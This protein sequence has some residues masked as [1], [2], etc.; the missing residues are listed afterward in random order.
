MVLDVL[1]SGTR[2]YSMYYPV[3]L[4]GTTQYYCLRRSGG[5][6]RTTPRYYPVLL[7]ELMRMLIVVPLPLEADDCGS[8]LLARKVSLVLS[9]AR[10]SSL[11]QIFKKFH[12]W[13][14]NPE[15]SKCLV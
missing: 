9:A 2:W 14:D 13:A 1:P 12:L 6:T 10:G 5:T 11:L 7:V 3:L 4:D 15:I 8:L